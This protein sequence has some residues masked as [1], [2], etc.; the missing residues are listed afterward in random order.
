VYIKTN[1][2]HRTFYTGV[3]NDLER[4]VVERIQGEVKGFTSRC[5]LNRLVWFE[6]YCDANDAIARK[7][8]I[9]RWLRS[10]KLDLINSMNPDW[11]D[12]LATDWLQNAAPS[13]SLLCSE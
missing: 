2:N 10:K 6:S 4:G 12:D 7:K 1:K 13:D 5:H 8:T 9:K 3:T 11:K